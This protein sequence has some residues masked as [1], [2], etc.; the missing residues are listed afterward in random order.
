MNLIRTQHCINCGIH[1]HVFHTC[2]SPVTSYGII[3]IRYLDNTFQSTLFSD[4]TIPSSP[5]IEFL[6]IQRKNSLSFNEFIIG[7]YSPRDYDYIIKILQG[8][9]IYEQ[10]LLVTK[11]FPELWNHIWGEASQVKSYKNNYDISEK[12]FI[13][14]QP[15]LSQ[16]IKEYPS[17]WLEPEWGF[18]KGRRNPYENDIHC[19]IREFQEET[20]IKRNEFDIIQNTN[21]ICET[22]FGSNHIHY[23]HKYYFGVCNSSIE[24][25]LNKNNLHMTREIGNIKWF[26]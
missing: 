21:A 17:T 19:A 12:R 6:L 7:K 15:E 8:M 3:A 18:P 14:L 26:S 24:V 13:Q 4:S 20:G 11:T 2:I 1:G 10:E 9:T 23:C 25:E 5:S 22:F 16:W